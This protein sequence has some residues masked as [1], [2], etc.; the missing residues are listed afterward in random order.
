MIP[1]RLFAYGTLRSDSGLP[2]HPA[3][4]GRATV[5][6]RGSVPGWLFDLGHYP[7]LVSM[8]GSRDVV[9]GQV[10][11]IVQGAMTGV[12]EQLDAY[13]GA[14][15]VP[16]PAHEFR[17][18]IL[19]VTLESGQTISAWGYILNQPHGGLGRID[20][21]D[22]CRSMR[23]NGHVTPDPLSSISSLSRRT[24]NATSDL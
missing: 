18:E 11:E 14:E 10:Y 2:R 20:S 4:D 21:G 16:T 9:V 17:R 7:A 13:E 23:I 24:G 8:P 15:A 6:G 5:M 12:L 22:F 1:A 19:D 3:L